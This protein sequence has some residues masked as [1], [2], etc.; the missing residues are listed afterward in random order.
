MATCIPKK[1]L[2]K[3]SYV[4]FTVSPSAFGG[5]SLVLEVEKDTGIMV[6]FKKPQKY[7]GTLT[8]INHDGLNVLRDREI[9]PTNKLF[10]T[11]HCYE[12]YSTK[13]MDE[14]RQELLE[15]MALTVKMHRKYWNDVGLQI[16]KNN[17]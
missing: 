12:L 10:D 11:M 14:A 13:P 9:K 7:N 8:R 17:K 3:V 2:T 4:A 15:R 6:M 16:D 1:K 5:T